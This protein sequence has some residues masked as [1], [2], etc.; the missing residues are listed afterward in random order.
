MVLNKGLS[1][2]PTATDAKPMEIMKDFNI[3]TNKSKRKLRRMINPPRQP[4]PSDEPALFRN[5]NETKASTD[6]LT[7]GPKGVDTFEAIRLNIT[8]IEQCPT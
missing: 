8:D 3:F 4:R 5:P 1:F 6:S 2:E 7:L